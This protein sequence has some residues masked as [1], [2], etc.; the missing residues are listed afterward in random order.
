[1]DEVE[2]IKRRIDIVD[3][4]SNYLTLKKAGA[5]YKAVCP[6]HQ[7]KTPSMMVSPEKQIFKCFGCGEGGDIFSFVM[8][9][10]NLEFREA[11]EM[12]ADRA[13]VKL[14]RHD[15][16]QAQVQTDRKTRLYKI[17]D[18][19][20]QVFHKILTSHSAG[21]AALK[22]LRDRKLTDQTIKDFQIGYAP[23]A[24][25]LK[26]FLSK[27]GFCDQEIVEAGSPDRF[28]RRIMFPIRDTMG[29]TIAFTGR[30]TQKDQQPKYLNTADTII[31]HKGRLLYNLDQ[32]KAAIKQER[33]TI[34]VEGQ[35]DVI[36]SHQAGVKNVVATSGTA[37]TEE[38]LRILYRYT[39]NVIFSFDGDT[40]GL[41]TAKKAYEMAIAEK[42][43]VKM[44]ELGDFKDPGEMIAADSEAWHKAVKDAVPVVV[45]YFDLAFKK[46]G[47]D[48]EKEANFSAQEKKEIAKELLPIIKI[49]PDSIE[50]AHYIG[51]LA[52]KLGIKEEIIFTALE[53]VEGKT[54]ERP[55]ELAKSEKM[56]ASTMLLAILLRDPKKMAAATGK[57]SEK[58]FLV[59]AE[60]EIYIRLSKEYNDNKEITLA[61]LLA[62][63]DRGLKNE[64]TSLTFRFDNLYALEPEKEIEDFHELLKH[65]SENRREVLKDHYASEIKKA[66]GTKDIAKLK[67]LIK[68]FQDAISK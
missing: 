37:L 57:L 64:I 53:R 35:M 32:S 8:K 10:E 2:E 36:A 7:E 22:Y 51:L 58:D 67:A 14:S 25:I 21:K 34:V 30:V 20:A 5:N 54:A 6:F 28:F 50:Q 47:I 68:E 59:P 38:H 42:M 40:A 56:A 62:K 46:R 26:D 39:P 27:R 44:V 49:I 12:L 18:L 48:S 52:N 61:S 9:M 31:F 65:L 45:W 66:E 4:I 55:K 17:N 23:S 15:P 1:M 24:R 3:L 13:G 19:S 43:N 60:K 63:V 11:L 29:H 33:A 16:K 41:A